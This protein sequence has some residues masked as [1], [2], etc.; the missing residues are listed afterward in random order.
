MNFYY[1]DK[2]ITSKSLKK[3]IDDDFFSSIRVG[4]Q[5]L[6]ERFFE[7]IGSKM[8]KIF[9]VDEIELDDCKEFI[10]CTSNITFKEGEYAKSFFNM[11]R[12][13]AIEYVSECNSGFVFKG[14][15]KSLINYMNNENTVDKYVNKYIFE[16]EN[17]FDLKKIIS[18]NFHSRYF[19]SVLKKDNKII[20]KSNQ[21]TKL[22]SEYLFLKSIPTNLKPFYAE[23]FD[24]KDNDSFY[25]YSVQEYDM[26]DMAYQHINGSTDM[27]DMKGLFEVLKSY[28]HE[29]MLSHT[30]SLGTETKEII[31]KNKNR[32][33]ELEITKEFS[34]LNSFLENHTGTNL[35]NH[36]LRIESK[37]KENEELINSKGRVLSHGD[38]CFSNILFSP[39]D[40]EIKLI[41]PRGLDNSNG[42][43]SPYYDMAKLS[44][45]LL[46][47]YDFIVNNMTKLTFDSSMKCNNELSVTK[48]NDYGEI[49]KD[50]LTDFNLDFKTVRL[51][52]SSLFLSMLP[53]HIED[54]KKVFSLALRSVEIFEEIYER[55]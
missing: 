29:V 41:D 11:L 34:S 5:S 10:L 6:E 31:E 28:F 38:L 4:K 54:T 51:I 37:L 22:E 2:K 18:S 32:F 44:H 1:L 3:I 43:R 17:I 27:H 20:K 26:F 16:I 19:N 13:S 30:K 7:M 46:G 48:E 39:T 36:H 23:A 12:S 33:Q 53:L 42:L 49:F 8:K 9:H 50:F 45:S 40:M 15:K 55:G 21:K 47:E 35:S 24:G 25:E 14:T 52:E